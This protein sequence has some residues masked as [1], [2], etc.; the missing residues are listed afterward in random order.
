MRLYW[1]FGI[2]RGQV[3]LRKFRVV[4][5]LRNFGKLRPVEL[6]KLLIGERGI[7]SG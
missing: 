2:L 6:Q 7:V 3:P 1:G 5:P 4:E